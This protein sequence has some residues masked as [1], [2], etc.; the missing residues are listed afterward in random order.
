MHVTACFSLSLSISAS[1]ALADKEKVAR[2]RLLTLSLEPFAHKIRVYMR[3]F[4]PKGL[5]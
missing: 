5:R 3:E 4:L 2:H 1:L